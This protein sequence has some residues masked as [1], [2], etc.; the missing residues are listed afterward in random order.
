MQCNK[1]HINVINGLRVGPLC[2]M[3]HLASLHTLAARR[4]AAVM[5]CSL[6]RCVAVPSFKGV[7]LQLRS[8]MAAPRQTSGWLSHC[9]VPRRPHSGRR[10]DNMATAGRVVDR[11]V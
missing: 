5:S 10:C 7:M 8:G 9:L 11:Y 1:C 2:I 3:S 4:P 6:V